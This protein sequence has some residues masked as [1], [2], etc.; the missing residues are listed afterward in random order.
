MLESSEN[1]ALKFAKDESLSAQSRALLLV[2]EPN[3]SEELGLASF[4][5]EKS[6]KKFEKSFPKCLTNAL[7]SVIM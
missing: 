4:S 1:T 2:P 3:L 6:S 5:G 7:V